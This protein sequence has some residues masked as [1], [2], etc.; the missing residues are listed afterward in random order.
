MMLIYSLL[1]RRALAIALCFA[2]IVGHAATP[3]SDLYSAV[4][5]P[6]ADVTEALTWVRDGE[7]VQ[8]KFVAAA[9]AL[10][11]ERAKIATLNGGTMPSIPISVAT[12][13]PD[14]VEVQ[15]ARSFADYLAHAQ[16]DAAP[17]AVLGKRKRWLQAAFGRSQLEISRSMAPCDTPCTDTAVIEANKRLVSRRDYELKTEIRAWNAMFDDWKTKQFGALIAADTYIEAA[18][19]GAA[20]TAQGRSIIASYQA[21]MLDEIELLLSITKL[22]VLRAEAIVKGLDG[23]EPDAISGATKKAAK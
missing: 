12:S 19:G 20:T 9:A 16:G 15:A 11:A 7:I 23:S 17:K 6:P 14:S 4:P 8:A 18:G 13:I 2:A 1:I 21:A 5:R 22:C 10:A 3:L